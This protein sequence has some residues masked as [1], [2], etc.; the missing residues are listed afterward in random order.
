M[1]SKKKE[2]PTNKSNRSIFLMSV[3]VLNLFHGLFHLIQFAQS[4]FI[5]AYSTQ[6]HH[7]HNESFID[8]IMHSPIFAL[9]MG[10]VGVLTLVVGINDYRHHNKC[11][12]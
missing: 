8:S 11:E 4:M 3:G 1:K 12:H 6:E 9:I 2:E 10:V 7:Q 5:V